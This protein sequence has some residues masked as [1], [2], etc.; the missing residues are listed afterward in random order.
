MKYGKVEGDLNSPPSTS[1]TKVLSES[2]ASHGRVLVCMARDLLLLKKESIGEVKKVMV[3]I[4]LVLKDMVILCGPFIGGRR[5]QMAKY[6]HF[7]FTYF[8]VSPYVICFLWKE[9]ELAS[10][11]RVFGKSYVN[12]MT[13]SSEYTYIY[14]SDQLTWG[15]FIYILV[16]LASLLSDPAPIT[17][18]VCCM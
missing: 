9:K 3:V 5:L 18:M 16:G 7:R 13:I 11:L 10:F 17:F 4:K 2:S 15:F 6:T 12:L 1:N 14:A 8:V